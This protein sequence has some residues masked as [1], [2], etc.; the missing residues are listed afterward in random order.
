MPSLLIRELQLCNAKLKIAFKFMQKKT[1]E[2]EQE[3]NLL[4]NWP[5][6]NNYL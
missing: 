4:D 5:I 3:V 6:N 2:A 1:A